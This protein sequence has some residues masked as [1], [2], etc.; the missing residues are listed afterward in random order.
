MA[1][2]EENKKWIPTGDG[3]Q[4]LDYIK[5]LKQSMGSEFYSQYMNN[6]VDSEYQLFK[7][8][9]FQY[10]DHR[11]YELFIATTVDPA[12]TFKE[13]GDYTAII[14]C[15]MDREGKIYILDALQGHWGTP[16]QI[17]DK[18]FETA[19]KWKPQVIGIESNNWQ[20]TLKWWAEKAMVERGTPLPLTELKAPSNTKKELRIKGLEP[21]YK[22]HMVYHARWMRELEDQLTAFTPEGMKAKH[23]D[24]IDALSYQ[25]DLLVPG[26]QADALTAPEGSWEWEFQQA[27]ALN[28]PYRD[29]FK[30]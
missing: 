4:S 22:N 14:T 15:G 27:E 7:K 26:P 10:Y 2:D 30:E 11:P 6:P 17:I 20:K 19:D 8:K 18:I 16:S 24:L 13:S 23:D 3:K 21:Y 29:F 28:Q 12:L 9:D 25:I 1:F 5:F